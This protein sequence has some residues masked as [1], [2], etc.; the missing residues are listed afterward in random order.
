[1]GALLHILLAVSIAKLNY[2]LRP[3]NR[4]LLGFLRIFPVLPQTGQKIILP[5]D[6]PPRAIQQAFFRVLG[7]PLKTQD[8]PRVVC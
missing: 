5:P 2:F 1:M 7:Q 4:V 3:K 6:R 8:F